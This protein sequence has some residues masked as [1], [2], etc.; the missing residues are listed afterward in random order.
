MV[1]AVDVETP[2]A[3]NW[4]DEPFLMSAAWEH[5][6]TGELRSRVYELSEEYVE[7]QTLLE[8]ATKFVFHNAKFDLQKLILVGLI[9]REDVS[10]SL[11]EDT[12]ALAHLLDE[13]QVKKL[14]PLAE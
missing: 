10:A 2:T 4:Y 1:L 12:E 6:E 3:D 8:T 7:A 5:E 9:K 11:I 14:K 13:H